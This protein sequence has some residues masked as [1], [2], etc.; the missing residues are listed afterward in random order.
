[1][2]SD[3]VLTALHGVLTD[4][5]TAEADVPDIARNE[6]LDDAFQA[7]DTGADA[8]G[9]MVDGDLSRTAEMLGG[10]EP[11]Q[12]RQTALL[13]LIVKAST[14]AER[15]AALKAILSKVHLA[16]EASTGSVATWEITGLD[17]LDQSTDADPEAGGATVEITCEFSSDVPY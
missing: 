13:E 10:A 3:D 9:N 6:T 14:D 11:Y 8:Y 16:L 4:L 17:R 15:R 12:M 5:A 1:M 2:S 7:L